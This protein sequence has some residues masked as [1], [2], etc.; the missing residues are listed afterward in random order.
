MYFKLKK[1]KFWDYREIARIYGD[2][3]SEP[4]YNEPWTFDVALKKIKIFSKY[5]D[6]WKIVY[7]TEIIGFV[8][9]N[10][11]HWYPGRTC[12]GEDI[13]IKKEYRGEGIGKEVLKQIMPKNAEIPSSFEQAG[14]LYYNNIFKLQK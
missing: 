1:A 6:I 12:F 10:P 5:C 13:S 7:G 11:H 3:F 8:I 14:L 9:V 2:G 4:P